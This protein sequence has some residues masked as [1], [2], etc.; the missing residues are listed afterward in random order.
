MQIL[1]NIFCKVRYLHLTICN[2]CLIYLL[3]LYH[4]SKTLPKRFK[5]THISH[6]W[7]RATNNVYTFHKTQL[8]FVAEC[9]VSLSGNWLDSLISRYPYSCWRMSPSKVIRKYFHTLTISEF[10]RCNAQWG[11]IIEALCVS[12]FQILQLCLRV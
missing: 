6:I 9:Q 5:Q 8:K 12:S 7:Q 1:L 4:H 11:L 3:H 2:N 10:R